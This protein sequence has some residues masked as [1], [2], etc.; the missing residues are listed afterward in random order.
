[1]APAQLQVVAPRFAV[2]TFA[3]HAVVAREGEHLDRST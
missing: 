2:R 3:R 1:M